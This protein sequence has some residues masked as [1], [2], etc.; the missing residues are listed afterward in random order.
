MDDTSQKNDTVIRLSSHF[1]TG[2]RAA[3][4]VSADRV[5]SVVLD[6]ER[7]EPGFCLTE[8][9]REQAVTLYMAMQA[10]V[11]LLDAALDPTLKDPKD[12]QYSLIPADIFFKIVECSEMSVTGEKALFRHGIS[13]ELH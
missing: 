5:A 6:A 9:A 1:L 10:M 13:L 12:E 8:V 11:V 4:S 3:S 7:D 2:L